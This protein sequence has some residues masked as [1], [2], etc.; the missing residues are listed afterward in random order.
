MQVVG[1]TYQNL[2]AIS[3]RSYI[4]SGKVLEII[5]AV[6]ATGAVTVIFDD[7]LSPGQQRTLE[8]MLGGEVRILRVYVVQNVCAVGS[9]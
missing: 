6:K 8:K 1:S 9:T 3:P 2:E 5:E 4:G 7:E